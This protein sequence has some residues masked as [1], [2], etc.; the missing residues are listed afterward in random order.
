MKGKLVSKTLRIIV[1]G[2]GG[3]GTFLIEGLTRFLEYRFP[4]S[5][6]FIIDGD[7]YEEKNKERQIFDGDGNKAVV[8]AAQLQPLF[9]NTYIV[10][11]PH[12]IV[13]KVPENYEF[14]IDTPGGLIP[15]SEFLHEDDIVFTTVDNHSA[16]KAVFDAAKN[17]DNISVFT[18]GNDDKL[19]GSTY[20]YQRRDG[21]EVTDHPSVYHDDFVNPPDKNPGEMSC[22]ERLKHEG[23]TQ[24]LAI[25]MG[26][27][28]VLLGRL[29]HVIFEENVDD[30]TEI[31][32]DLGKVGMAGHDRL[33]EE[34]S[35]D[36]Q[37]E[38]EEKVTV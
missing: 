35:V 15:A 13:D 23:G 10:P 28:A 37:E 31:Y 26:V 29:H 14:E 21:K 25:N 32:F 1:V 6:L 8:K 5:S 22:E 12:W 36:S 27:A 2:A 34:E 19:F 30:K 11:V 18:G 38:A 3:T 4:G 9:S 24:L 16:R 7:E 20:H 17:F 33:A